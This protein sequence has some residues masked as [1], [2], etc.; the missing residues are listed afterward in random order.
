MR[1]WY[2]FLLKIFPI[3][4]PQLI[5]YLRSSPRVVYERLER[6]SRPEELCVTKEYLTQIH[7]FYEPWLPDPAALHPESTSIPLS[8]TEKKFINGTLP[9]ATLLPSLQW[10][11]HTGTEGPMD[12]VKNPTV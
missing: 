3:L 2:E 9:L 7:E 10:S 11:Y 4:R 12:F 8:S 5:V 6:R 1:D